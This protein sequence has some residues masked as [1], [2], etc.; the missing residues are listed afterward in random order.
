M[1][2]LT[3]AASEP[4]AAAFDDAVDTSSTP[5]RSCQ[6][7]ISWVLPS[8]WSGWRWRSRSVGRWADALGT[9]NDALDRYQA[10]GQ[11]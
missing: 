3:I 10:L 9:M 6:P 7:M 8:C 5:S 1:R 2:Y 4:D 11:V